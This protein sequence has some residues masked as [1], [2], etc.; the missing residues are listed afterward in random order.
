MKKYYIALIVLVA[1][2]AIYCVYYRDRT[3]GEDEFSLFVYMYGSGVETERLQLYHNDVPI[4][5]RKFKLKTYDNDPRMIFVS[6]LKK[7]ELTNLRF[8]LE[9]RLRNGHKFLKDIDSTFSISTVD[10]DSIWISYA[11]FLGLSISDISPLTEF[12]KQDNEF[13]LFVYLHPPYTSEEMQVYHNDT[14]LYDGKIRSLYY[15]PYLMFVSNVKKGEMT[16]L[17][18]KSVDV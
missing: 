9:D 1:C 4:F 6:N 8:K 15:D 16:R 7:G 14:L 11:T 10:P 3:P 17:R 2:I 12:K 18:L 5:N 13:A